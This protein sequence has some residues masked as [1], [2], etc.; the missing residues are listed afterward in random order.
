MRFP[1]RAYMLFSIS[2]PLFRTFPTAG[3]QV[4]AVIASASWG[5]IKSMA[6][7]VPQ[8]A[9]TIGRSFWVGRSPACDR[10]PPQPLA[11]GRIL[12]AFQSPANANGWPSLIR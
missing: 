1:L 2:G 10:G 6:A 3:F 9:P 4:P 7:G 8:R 11:V 5:R 12:Q